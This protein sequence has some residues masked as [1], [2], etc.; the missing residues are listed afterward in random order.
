MVYCESL[1]DSTAALQDYFFRTWRWL[2]LLSTVW[3]FEGFHDCA[4]HGSEDPVDPWKRLV[5]LLASWAEG[6]D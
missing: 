3:L 6:R 4:G 2:I 5:W 1:Q